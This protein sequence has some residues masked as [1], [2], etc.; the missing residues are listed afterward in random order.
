MSLENSRALFWISFVVKGGTNVAFLHDFS[1]VSGSHFNKAESLT[2]CPLHF[3]Y[4]EPTGEPLETVDRMNLCFF[5][6]LVILPRFRLSVDS[7]QSCGT[8]LSL[9]SLKEKKSYKEF[10]VKM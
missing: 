7:L 4:I 10:L 8:C 9:S 6:T 1:A 5:M 2:A 3:T